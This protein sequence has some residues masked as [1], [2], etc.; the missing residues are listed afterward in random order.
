MRILVLMAAQFFFGLGLTIFNIG[1]VS[2]RQTVTPDHLQGRMN[3]T[4][5]FIAAGSVPLGGLLGG[6]LGEMMVLPPF[7]GS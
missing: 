6:G 2:V 1:Q 5:S 7:A 4:L 3:A